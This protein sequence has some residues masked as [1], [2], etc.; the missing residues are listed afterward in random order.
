MINYKKIIL[1]I[2]LFNIA[3]S[4]ASNSFDSAKQ[5]GENTLKLVSQSMPV[6]LFNKYIMAK[7]NSYFRAKQQQSL[8][9]DFETENASETKRKILKADVKF[10]CYLSKSIKDFISKLLQK[11][12]LKRMPLQDILLHQWIVEHKNYKYQ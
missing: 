1:L 10:P 6:H 11:D 8:F 4:C 9:Y 3:F 2:L 12:P 7:F 5:A